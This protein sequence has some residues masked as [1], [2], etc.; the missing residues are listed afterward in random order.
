[1]QDAQLLQLMVGL[2]TLPAATQSVIVNTAVQ[3]QN[4]NTSLVTQEIV[5]GGGGCGARSCST[6]GG[7]GGSALA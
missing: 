5:R 4:R 3:T 1:M 6:F 7:G 2:V